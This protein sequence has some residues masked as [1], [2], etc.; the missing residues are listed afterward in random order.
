MGKIALAI[1]CGAL[2]IAVAI[3]LS[4]R[5]RLS[6]YGKNWTRLDHITG[7][8]VVCSTNEEGGVNVLFEPLVGPILAPHI[9]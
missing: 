8:F 4:N 6:V 2:A 5:Y 7:E 9:C 3:A 1:V